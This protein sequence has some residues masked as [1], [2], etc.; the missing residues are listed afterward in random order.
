MSAHERFAGVINSILVES[1]ASIPFDILVDVGARIG[2]AAADV[3][4]ADLKKVRPKPSD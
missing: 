1:H 2:D 4:I 3:R